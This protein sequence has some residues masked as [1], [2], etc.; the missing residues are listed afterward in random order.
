VKASVDLTNFTAGELSPRMKS[1]DDVSKYYNGCDTELNMVTM[2]Q[3]GATRRPGT[4]YVAAAI[5]ALARSRLIEFIFSELQ[6]YVTEWGNF[7]ARIYANDGQV[8]SGGGPVQVVTP[9]AT[10]DTT[11]LQ[12]VQSD[13]E[14]FLCHPSYPTQTLN[15]TSNTAWT[16]TPLAFRDG[17]YLNVNTTPTTLTPSA[18]TGAITLTASSIVGING[19]LGFQ[20]LDVGRH[21]RLKL[22]A[23]WGWIAIT[24]VTSTLIVHGTVQPANPNGAFGLDGAAWLAS[25]VYPAGAIVL[26]GSD[27][28]T[29]TT[30]GTS[31]SSGGPT[32]AGA[33]IQD[34][35]AVWGHLATAP[36]VASID[37][38][39]GKWCGTTGYPFCPTFWQ[40]RLALCGTNNQPNALELS[41]VGDFSNFAPTQAD[42]SVSDVNA[43]SW[44]IDDDGVNAVRWLSPAGSAQA[45]Q[46]GVGTV[47]GEQIMQAATTAQA[48]TA[49]SVQAYRETSLGSAPNV[50]PLRILKSVLFFN[51]PGRKLHEWTFQ[52]QVNGYLG[53]DLS[54]LAEHITASG[55]TQMAYQQSPY[56]V[57][58]MI[59]ADGALIGL[60]YLREQEIVAWHRHQLGGQYYGGPPIVESVVVIPSPDQSYD[61]VWLEVLRT[62]N[63]V[64][65]RFI[66]VMTR[67]F[68]KMPLDQAWFLDAAVS[69]VLTAPAAD[70]TP[71]GF[72]NAQTLTGGAP[73]WGGT[74][75]LTADAG[76]FS[77][78][79]VRQV[80][81]ANGGSLTVTAYV[82]ATQVT[83][84]V[85]QPMTSLAPALTGA[86]TMMPLATVFSGVD[87]LNGEI[88]GVLGDGQD[89]GSQVP[90]GGNVT[91]ASPGASLVTV[92]LP[93]VPLIVTMPSSPQRAAQAGV[94]GRVKRVDHLFVRFLETVG[95]IVGTRTTDPMT[96]AVNDNLETI[97]S[98]SAADPMNQAPPLF[99]GIRKMDA[100][101]PH[102]RE[103]ELII[104]QSGPLPLT[105]L[106]IG[107]SVDLEEMAQP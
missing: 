107:A 59:R 93:Y 94:Q 78:G 11:A 41:V 51:R 10:A 63:G 79:S 67:Y 60:T 16:L 62:V 20:A 7:L 91:L 48:L 29:C 8:Q 42:G 1:R 72:T 2:P 80:V 99:T 49:A 68:D 37:W 85:L 19:G 69:N 77:S 14:L 33:T 82:S 86:W 44:I 83:A 84:Q 97:R 70:L 25:T 24:S 26:N 22:Q 58:W 47:A 66:E 102:D 65:V 4:M 5:S 64:P 38:A 71:S 75:T 12:Y 40:Q 32:G 28:Y 15:R 21:V 57:I 3:G 100:R 43:L 52:W 54:V 92:G 101:G 36:A 90:T 35:T 61:E 96:G 98:R 53:P 87:A 27:Y 50:R 95:G 104:T 55:V 45:M 6:P 23:L 56:G 103:Q 9:Y 13:D 18:L 89:F 74:G 105:V 34:N 73:A 31:A 46:L 39:L 17:P 106:G 88:V 81:R 30:A 76:V